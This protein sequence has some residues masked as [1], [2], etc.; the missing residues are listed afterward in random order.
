MHHAGG[1]SVKADLIG[2][3]VL[4][5]EVGLLGIVVSRL[6]IPFWGWIVAYAALGTIAIGVWHG[7]KWPNKSR[8]VLLAV[9][10]TFLLGGLF[11]ACDMILGRL[12]HPDLSLVEAAEQSGGPLGF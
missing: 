10:G 12:H 1:A 2:L 6:G 4:A 5:G 7:D 8:D 3:A 9:L 11:F